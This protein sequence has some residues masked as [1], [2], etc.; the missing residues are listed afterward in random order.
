MHDHHP[1]SDRI[2][3]AGAVTNIV[4]LYSSVMLTDVLCQLFG[5]LFL[6]LHV[7]YKVCKWDMCVNRL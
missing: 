6:N 1:G 3:T 2:S 7:L 5:F 4:S